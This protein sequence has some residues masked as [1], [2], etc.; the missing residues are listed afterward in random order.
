MLR[1]LK[2][3]RRFI[4][5]TSPTLLTCAAYT[6]QSATK[7]LSS[8]TMLG[9]TQYIYFINLNGLSFW[10]KDISP[11]LYN[12]DIQYKIFQSSR[13]INR[14]FGLSDRKSR[15]YSY[16]GQVWIYRICWRL[17]G[18]YQRFRR[19]TVLGCIAVTPSSQTSFPPSFKR[20]WRPHPLIPADNMCTVISKTFVSLYCRIN[21]AYILAA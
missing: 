13:I 16:F 1:G 6:V 2:N 17:Q 12:L 3:G 11:S 14:G 20:V 18:S 15:K 21:A 5:T 4:K 10:G 9:P 7:L 8:F 19:Q